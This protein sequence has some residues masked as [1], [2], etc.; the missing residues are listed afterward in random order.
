MPNLFFVLP[1][2][3]IDKFKWDQRTTMFQLLSNMDVK[4]PICPIHP[5]KLDQLLNTPKKELMEKIKTWSE[6]S[7][8]KPDRIGLLLHEDIQRVGCEDIIDVLFFI[9]HCGIYRKQ[10]VG[11]INKPEMTD[12]HN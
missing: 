2:S 5:E 12:N 9:S 7:D 1:R 4:I 10:I 8:T 3:S 11:F 6:H